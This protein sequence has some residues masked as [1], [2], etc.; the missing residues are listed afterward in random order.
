MDKESLHCSCTVDVEQT[1]RSGLFVVW[2]FLI[3][4]IWH[5]G[6]IFRLKIY[7]KWKTWDQVT[8]NSR[9]EAQYHLHVWNRV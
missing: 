1:Q 2:F 8:E 6:V 9:Q 7:A 5:V 3:L 4:E